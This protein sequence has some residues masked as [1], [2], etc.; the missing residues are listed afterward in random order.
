MLFAREHIP[1]RIP[2]DLKKAELPEAA[3]SAK[4]E[5]VSGLADLHMGEWEKN[6]DN[7]Y[8]MDGTQWQIRIEYEDGRRPV[9]IGGSNAYPYNFSELMEL[10]GID[11]EENED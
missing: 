5:F 2:E 9:E 7:P 3:P 6:Y 11:E 8:V 4:E 10:L 1:C